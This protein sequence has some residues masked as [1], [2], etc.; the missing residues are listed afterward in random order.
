[1]ISS[2]TKNQNPL[3]KLRAKNKRVTIKAVLNFLKWAEGKNKKNMIRVQTHQDKNNPDIFRIHF[4]NPAINFLYVPS[5]QTC[6]I[7]IGQLNQEVFRGDIIKLFHN[8]VD[9]YKEKIGENID[10]L[11]SITENVK[12][13]KIILEQVKYLFSLYFSIEE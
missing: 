13:D 10:K 11:V 6:C 3:I 5:N 9:L 12:K 8:A 4:I 1:M 7:Q 2:K